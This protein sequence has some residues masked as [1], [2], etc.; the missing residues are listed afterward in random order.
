MLFQYR[1]EDGENDGI[2]IPENTVRKTLRCRSIN[3]NGTEAVE[4]RKSR[5]HST[6]NTLHT[7]PV[8][9]LYSPMHQTL[10]EDSSSSANSGELNEVFGMTKGIHEGAGVTPGLRRR[11]ERAERQKSFLREQ[12]EAVTA[13]KNSFELKDDNHGKHIISFLFLFL[14][15]PP[16]AVCFYYCFI[17]CVQLNI[18][19]HVFVFCFFCDFIFSIFT[20][21]S[22]RYDSYR[23]SILPTK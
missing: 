12:Q 10:D 20:T 8:T 21:N 4:R 1:F 14:N 19:S 3:M 5:R 23:R 13:G 16:F 2:C 11:R 22:F 17:L 18:N 7:S 15:C 6:E 9:K